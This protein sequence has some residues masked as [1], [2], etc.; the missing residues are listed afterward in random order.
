MKARP[1]MGGG[2]SVITALSGLRQEDHKFKANLSCI[3]SP[4]LRVEGIQPE[5]GMKW[6]TSFVF[7]IFFGIIN[8]CLDL[9]QNVSGIWDYNLTQW[10]FNFFCLHSS[11]S[12]LPLTTW[13]LKSITL[14]SLFIFKL[15]TKLDKTAKSKTLSERL[16]LLL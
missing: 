16:S 9:P 8:L 12:T 2:T 10:L 4:C 6:F 13:Q 3:A 5:V 14:D 7:K 15:E 11:H 1:G